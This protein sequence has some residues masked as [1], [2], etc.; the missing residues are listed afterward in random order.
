[1]NKIPLDPVTEN[2][3]VYG[4]SAN[5]QKYQLATTL[6]NL[7][8]NTLIPTTYANGTQARVTGNYTY[9]LRL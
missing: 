9:P 8:T 3:Y 7:Q 4:V 1:M 6:E 5:H 2:K